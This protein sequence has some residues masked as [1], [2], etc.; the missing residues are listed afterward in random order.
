[1]K[2]SEILV[3]FL[4]FILL[5]IKWERLNIDLGIRDISKWSPKMRASLEQVY[6]ADEVQKL[7][8]EFVDGF[9]DA[10]GENRARMSEKDLERIR[11]HTLIVHGAKDEL[12]S[13]DHPPYLK[14]MIRFNE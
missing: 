8:S 10:F 11:A 7:W 4:F 14:K 3:F 1:M 2:V 9:P 12:V 13:K 5:V 6:G